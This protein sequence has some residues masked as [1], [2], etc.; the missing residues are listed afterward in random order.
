MY[1][2]NAFRIAG[3]LVDGTLV[4]GHVVLLRKSLEEK[5]QKN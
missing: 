4:T 5:N 1:I 3:S 2:L